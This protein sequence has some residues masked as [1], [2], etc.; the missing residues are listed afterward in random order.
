MTRE[1]V[2]AAVKAGTPKI[3]DYP[4]TLAK[5]R[6]LKPGNF[7]SW[8]KARFLKKA[9]RLSLL[10]LSGT[11]LMLTSVVRMWSHWLEISTSLGFYQA[12]GVLTA[13]SGAALILAW[14]LNTGNE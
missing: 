14:W 3:Y 12:A 6:S 8:L 9:N 13:V 2:R 1:N 5:A 4:F 10:F 11:L 7:L